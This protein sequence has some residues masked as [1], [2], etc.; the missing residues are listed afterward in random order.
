MGLGLIGSSSSLDKGINPTRN[1][2][3]V[4]NTIVNR[5]P[6]PDPKNY[7]IIKHSQYNNHVL[8]WI[9]YPDCNN[10]EGNKILLFKDCSL[11][12]LQKQKV[13]DPHFSE[14][15]KYHSP[16]ARFEPTEKGWEMGKIVMQ[17]IEAM[18]GNKTI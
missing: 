18:N 2:V 8:L 9:K 15:K 16:F 6:N 3:I 14:N 17:M 5:L 13:I 12:K 10:Y 1:T 11:H 4:N 7:Q